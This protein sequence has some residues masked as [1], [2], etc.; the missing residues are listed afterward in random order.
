MLTRLISFVLIAGSLCLGTVA[1][2]TAYLPK[3]SAVPRPGG[4]EAAALTMGAPAG[5]L[6]GGSPL[7]RPGTKLT[8]A[9][10]DQ[11]AAADPP[12]ERVKVKEF[13]LGRWDLA[14]LFGLSVAGLIGGATIVRVDARRRIAAMSASSGGSA[15]GDRSPRETL[16]A[17]HERIAA[18]RQGGGGVADARRRQAIIHELDAARTAFFEPFVEMRPVIVAAVGMSGYARVMDA[19]AAAERAFN[20]AWSAAADGYPQEAEE[21][22][23]VGL[24]RLAEAVRRSPG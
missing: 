10:L 13:S 7:V 22:L 16:V 2:S 9:V 15:A 20:R 8:D 14:W 11:L 23:L 21:S 24:E 6:P 19:F 18:L 12:V 5:G 1:A 4:D 3:L 17:A